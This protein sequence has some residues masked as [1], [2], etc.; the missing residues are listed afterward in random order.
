MDKAATST[1]IKDL[2]LPIV[3]TLSLVIGI[4]VGLTHLIS[5]SE[6]AHESL[7]T[8]KIQSIDHIDRFIDHYNDTQASRTS[9]ITQDLSQLEQEIS[10]LIKVGQSG[11]TIYH[12]EKLKD[13]RI[14]SSYWERVGALIYLKY[15][16]FDIMYET[17]PFP[18]EFW[19]ST[20]NIRKLLADNWYGKGLVLEEFLVNID[21]LK[22]RYDKKSAPA[23][24]QH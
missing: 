10:Q 17:V 6:H 13:Y 20:G 22:Q 24:K 15:I 4:I 18:K 19:S 16:D 3:N 1:T 7:D 12:S 2:I 5:L 21:R 23:N 14:V 9:L 8:L 11:Q